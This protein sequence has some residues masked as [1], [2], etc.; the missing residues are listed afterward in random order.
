MLNVDEYLQKLSNDESQ[1]KTDRSSNNDSSENTLAG[2]NVHQKSNM[3]SE[4]DNSTDYVLNKNSSTNITDKKRIGTP[5]SKN[6]N[7]YGKSKKDMKE[8]M[9]NKLSKTRQTG[10]DAVFMIGES[11]N[12]INSYFN[13]KKLC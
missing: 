9:K 5:S 11:P 7:T 12:F 4:Y 10:G 6:K 1:P 2:K 8:F 13:S 3:D